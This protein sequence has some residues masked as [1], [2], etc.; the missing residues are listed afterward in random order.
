[1]QVG[2]DAEER[3]LLKATF[4]TSGKASILTLDDECFE[5]LISVPFALISMRG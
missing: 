5:L 2:K 3:P 4:E 1:M